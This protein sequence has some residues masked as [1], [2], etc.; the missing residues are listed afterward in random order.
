MSSCKEDTMIKAEGGRGCQW[1]E[2][3]NLADLEPE[4]YNVVK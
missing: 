4:V 2:N 1:A 3:Q